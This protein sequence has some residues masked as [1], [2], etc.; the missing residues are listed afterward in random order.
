[1]DNLIQRLIELGYNLTTLEQ[2]GNEIHFMHRRH[3][4]IIEQLNSGYQLKVNSPKSRFKTMCAN[5]HR[6]V[7]R[8]ADYFC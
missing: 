4:V 1:M 7:V 2:N 8:V 6:L 5:E 3:L